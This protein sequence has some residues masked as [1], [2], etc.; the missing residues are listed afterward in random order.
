M[1][2]ELQLVM[3]IRQEGQQVL[4]QLQNEMAQ[5]GAVSKAMADKLKLTNSAM[6]DADGISKRLAGGMGQAGNVFRQTARDMNDLHGSGLRVSAGLMGVVR[7]YGP[8]FGLAGGA[9][10]FAAGM[11]KSVSASL[12]FS[13]SLTD[14]EALVGVSHQSMVQMKQD[15]LEVSTQF[16]RSPK[17]VAEAMYFITSSGFSGAE[18]MDALKA[19]AMGAAAGMGD[20]KTVADAA[21]SASNA[22]GH[23]NLKAS[24]AI[25]VLLA[26]VR[27]GKMEPAQLAAAMGQVTAVA[28]TTGTTFRDVAGAAAALS[29]NGLPAAESITTIRQTLLAVSAPGKQARD[30]LEKLGSSQ[31]KVAAVFRDKGYLAGLQYLKDLT[32][33][34][35][36]A[37]GS[38][39]RMILQDVQAVNAAMALTGKNAKEAQKAIAEV[40]AAGEKDLR[41]AFDIASQSA[42][43]SMNQGLAL[44]QR[45]AIDV[46]D[47]A[48]PI[49]ISGVKGAIDAFDF[50]SGHADQLTAAIGGVSVGVLA[51]YTLLGRG[52]LIA[53]ANAVTALAGSFVL[54]DGAILTATGS[55][56]TFGSALAATGI[57]AIAIALGVLT[58]E[59]IR[60]NQ[61][62]NRAAVAQGVYDSNLKVAK[63]DS[64]KVATA[65][66]T[67]ATAHGKARDKAL[68]QVQALRALIDMHLR[69]AE[70]ALRHA[71][72]EVGAKE[73]ILK[74]T[75]AAEPLG[76]AMNTGS[77]GGA[78]MGVIGATSAT[79]GARRNAD[80]AKANRD[81]ALAAVKTEKDNL[82]ALHDSLT[83]PLSLPPVAGGG[84]IDPFA[85]D[86]SRK[87]GRGGKSE[88]TQNWEDQTKAIQ[89]FLLEAQK[90]KAMTDVL[91]GN[92][93]AEGG[94]FAILGGL[95]DD[96]LDRISQETDAFYAM[97]QKA[98]D[99]AIAKGHVLSEQDVERIRNS[100]EWAATKA[101]VD[102]KV[103]AEQARRDEEEKRARDQQLS[104]LKDEAKLL[105]AQ[106]VTMK[107]LTVIEMA[108][109]EAAKHHRDVTAEDLA[110]ARALLNLQNRVDTDKDNIKGGFEGQLGQQDVERRMAIGFNTANKEQQVNIALWEKL[111][112]RRR[113]TGDLDYK[114]TAQEEE[115]VRTQV[116]GIQQLSDAQ[117]AFNDK[118]EEAMAFFDAS[119]SFFHDS[120]TGAKSLKDAFKD[121]IKSLID[122]IW[123][124]QILLPLK[125]AFEQGMG[126]SGSGG[127]MPVG[128]NDIFSTFFRGLGS[129]FGGSGGMDVAGNAALDSLGVPGLFAKGDVFSG[130]VGFPMGKGGRG[131]MAEAGPEAIMPLARGRDGKL[132]IRGGGDVT[133]A[134]TISVAVT[135]PDSN[136]DPAEFGR[137]IGLAIEAK[138]QSFVAKERRPGGV[139]SVR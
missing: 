20:M 134:P 124:Y 55:I 138:M 44:M 131:I 121:L 104:G 107:D 4:K 88:A 81:A 25:G 3:K 87:N 117:Q 122:L 16:G 101:A 133:F 108:R 137:I 49:L 28:A 29:L 21:T 86:G 50:M 75:H 130:P 105:E 95:S 32:A 58:Y 92:V 129:I 94:G 85:K 14:M 102:S 35:G 89:G 100:K 15:L 2:E 41:K 13:K 57:G 106:G 43:F 73:A 132:G 135:A 38:A 71:E 111:L 51:L 36:S 90:A 31:E 54:V 118:K 59:F 93:Q 125:R 60:Y 113:E 45:L 80:Q 78:L 47:K 37:Q 69:A 62:I 91:R 56:I 46:G 23:A 53:A 34:A 74:A 114:L 79:G 103:A 48:M 126:G 63:V 19:S 99:R 68:E 119:T 17:E 123:Q 110:N 127:L 96:A 98:Q 77:A 27:V 116:S 67:L 18:A 12:D 1:S 128:G 52:P 42:N 30:M 5:T 115:L 26:A 61:E 11:R 64:D 40:G 84:D 70:A 139:L 82:K 83:A 120:I 112:D 9:L 109:A 72:A 6:R 10:A 22:Y 7:A 136:A 24:D 76:G 8:L 66:Q 65:T 97:V 39:L 33:K